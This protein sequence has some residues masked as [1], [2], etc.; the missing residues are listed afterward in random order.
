MSWE[1]LFSR[2]TLGVRLG[3]SIVQGVYDAMGRPAAGIDAVHVVGTNGKGSI[4]AMVEHALRGQGMRT[5]LY[6]SPHLLRVG[7]RVRIDGEP[8]DDTRL[9]AHVD[10]VLAVEQAQALARPLSFFEL[11]TLAALDLLGSAGI[12]VLVAEA[13]LGGRLDATRLV[14][15]WTVA[16]ASIAMDHQE[17][18]G[19]TLTQV[20]G[21]KAAVFRPS[22]PV[23]SGPQ[24]PA[25]TAVLE[26]QAR[27]VGCALEFC[28]PLAQ[29]PRGL[30]GA[31]QRANAAVA[32]AV[33]QV[34]APSVRAEHLDGVRWPGRLQTMA[35]GGG[36]LVADVAH[37]PAALRSVLD[38]VADGVVPRPD[39]L[40]FGAQAHKDTAGM[41]QVLQT[42]TGPRWW[43]SPTSDTPPPQD[44]IWAHCSQSPQDPGFHRALTEALARGRTVLVCG[45]HLLVAAVLG[46]TRG[47]L[48]PADPQDPGTAPSG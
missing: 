9:R 29:S 11:L 33:A 20:A 12:D 45:S 4:A 42:W 14:Q 23:F 22:V 17:F 3:L 10:R 37:N 46:W 21:E 16:V 27:A 5:G 7:E 13:G 8:V 28:S 31:H 48:T 47:D 41:L 44:P 24:D 6:T 38:A 40:V 43:V 35:H 26:D 18:L 2:R 1:A 15:P 25:V 32:L 30:A 39:V 19:D 36:T 34:I